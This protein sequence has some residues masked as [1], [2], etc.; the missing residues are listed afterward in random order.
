MSIADDLSRLEQMHERGTL[1]DDE[2]ARAKER[3]LQG[4]GTHPAIDGLN[5]F[6]RQ[7][8]D[9]WIGGVCAGLAASTGLAAWI[10]RVLFA[11]LAFAGGS[12]L[13]IYLVLWIFVPEQR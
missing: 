13:L 5:N 3:L 2:F 8:E 10:W 9:R 1:S 7:R 4:G 11:V 6:R 12:G